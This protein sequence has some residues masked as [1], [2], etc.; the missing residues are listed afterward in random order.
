MDISMDKSRIRRQILA[1]RDR[2]DPE[3]RERCNAAIRERVF[4]H[5]AYRE[6]RI[7][8]AYVSYRSEVDTSE[9]IGQAL[10]DG[11]YVFAPKV[12]GGEME[13]WQIFSLEDLCSGYKGIPEPVRGIPLPEWMGRPNGSAAADQGEL[14]QYKIMMWMPGA[15]FD[16]ERHR[17]GYGKGFYDRYLGRLRDAKGRIG[18]VMERLTTA[19]FAYT[20]QLVHTIPYE[21]HDVRP[22]MVITEEGI[23]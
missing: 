11:K 20:C 4:V 8:L 15:V 16:R 21:V 23:L 2:M 13:F 9:M 10:A 22:D 1:V 12:C 5:Q 3:V 18:S 6:A 7:I 17:I 14:L 19:A